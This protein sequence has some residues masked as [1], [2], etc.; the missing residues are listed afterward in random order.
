MLPPTGGS[1]TGPFLVQGSRPCNP[2]IIE[3]QKPIIPMSDWQWISVYI[4]YVGLFLKKCGP[5][6]EICFFSM[7]GTGKPQLSQ[8]S[9]WCQCPKVHAPVMDALHVSR[10]RGSQGFALEESFYLAAEVEKTCM[11]HGCKATWGKTYVFEY[12]FNLKSIR[13]IGCEHVYGSTE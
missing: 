12:D 3:L 5:N 10:S 11:Q 13:A 2:N 4:V 1:F 8:V 9:S 6:K 7:P